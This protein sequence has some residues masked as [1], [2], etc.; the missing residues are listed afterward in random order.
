MKQNET[1]AA[2]ND[3]VQGAIVRTVD[4]LMNST[5]V[6]WKFH[7]RNS[8]FEPALNASKIYINRILLQQNASDPMNVLKPLAGEIDESYTINIGSVQMPTL[9]DGTVMITAV[10]SI[11]LVRALE[12]FTQLF[13]QTAADASVYTPYAPVWIHD[14]PKF[15]HRGLN[16]DVARSYYDYDDILRTIDGL[17]WNKM[18]VLHLHGTDAQSW[19]IQIPALPEL[20]NKG[21]YQPQLSYD[22]ETLAYIQEY[23]AYRGVQVIIET[24]M[25]GHTASIGFSHPELITAFNLQPWANYAAEPASGLL[26]LN[27]SAVYSFLDKLW[28]D[29][30]PRVMPYS[31]Y[32]HT[33]GDEL[34]VNAYLLDETVK[35]NESSVIKPLLQKFVDYN[36]G[37]VRAA[38]MIPVVWEDILLHWNL[39]LGE[40][41]V[42]QTWQTDA[43]V[44]NSV[45]K[46]FKTIAGNSDS[47]VSAPFFSDDSFID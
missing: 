26:K 23:G 34:N 47:W 25:P 12:M 37:K 36:H 18:N 7:P 46:G 15:A 39:T 16:M 19:P 8:N 27:S 17:A 35:S 40:D 20:A 45:A 28:A 4:V 1:S 5:I 13:Y 43:A 21:A 33:G 11:G 3:I 29:L 32:Y 9:V 14:A 38:G 10:S 24:D 44:A 6:P 30:L 22:P 41:V 2:S 31:A 42:V